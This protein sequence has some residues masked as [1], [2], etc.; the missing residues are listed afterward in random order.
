MRQGA[1]RMRHD[2]GAGGAVVRAAVRGAA[3]GLLVALLAVL[4]LGFSGT[5]MAQTGAG[6]APAERQTPTATLPQ[7]ASGDSGT[8]D[9]AAT[10]SAAHGTATG[11]AA[12]PT[13]ETAPATAGSTGPGAAGTGTASAGG[14]S[15]G[16]G[17]APDTT[18]PDTTAPD[19]AAPDS[20]APNSATD[21]ATDS[22]ATSAAP[23]AAAA[24]S[25]ATG[26]TPAGP[27]QPTPQQVEPDYKAWDMVATRGEGMVEAATASPDQLASLRADIV[28]WR[29][30]FQAAQSINSGRIATVRDQI[31]AL[32]PAPAEGQTEADDIAARRGQLTAQLTELQ[33]P[34]VRAVEAYSRA[35]ALVRSI[36]D[37]TRSRQTSAMLTQ[38][39]MPLLPSSL[40]AAWADGAKVVNGIV[41]DVRDRTYGAAGKAVVGRLPLV[42]AYLAVALWLLIFGRRW[43]D[44]LPSRL[45]SRAS[46]YTR[47]ALTFGVSLGQIAIPSA[48]A[49]LLVMALD[50]TGLAGSWARPILIALPLTALILFSGRWLSRRFFPLQSDPPICYSETLRLRGRFW[51]TALAAALA[52]HYIAST[53]FLPL[54]GVRAA[55]GGAG[56]RIPL[57]VS[58]AAAGV[59]HLPI[60]L[61]GA[62]C[63]YKL[64]CVL[65]QSH[66]FSPADT[67][68][69]RG[70]VI[71]ILG[72]IARVV[73]VVSPIAALIGYVTLG[74]AV[75]WSTT[76]SVALVALIIVLQ[77]LIADLWAIVKRDREGSRAALAPVLIGFALVV[78]SVPVFA[79][80]W[81][82]GTQDLAEG[83]SQLRQGVALGGVRLSP[84]AVLTFLVVFTAGYMLTRVVQGTV[85]NSILPR[86]RL[87]AGAQNAAVAGLG[88]VGVFL[89]ALLA[90][91]SAGIDLSSF[92][93]VAGALSVGIGFGMQ[94]IVSN[95]VSGIILLVERPVAVGDWIQVG[96]AQGYVRRISVRSTQI[97]TFDRTDVIVPNSDLISKEVT[98]WTRGNLQ[99]RI[100]VPVGVAYGSDTRKVTQILRDIAE[101]QPIVLINPAPSVL[102]VNFGADSLDFEIRAILSDVNQGQSVA[103]E[104]RHQII[105]RFAAEGIDI[106]YAHREV[107]I[108]NAHEMPGGPA[109]RAAASRR[110]GAG[111]GAG[112]AGGKADAAP[113]P[114]PAPSPAEAVDPRIAQAS[115]SGLEGA[116]GGSDGDGD[117]RG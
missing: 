28:N 78:A 92:A 97:Q 111:A 42:A 65:R 36:D 8:A 13:A 84:G 47:D 106:P 44:S 48:G 94:N 16:A 25:T 6:T 58:D 41:Q 57:Q 51:G 90:I 10:G 102:F 1:M 67:P 69:Y 63:L 70:K 2:G 72:E 11:T 34:S 32:G 85:R 86:T 50:T 12:E 29:D 39:P 108:V 77:E 91:T 37:L 80:I 103:T 81:G 15:A 101:D 117:G 79:L 52:V 53:V 99:G 17:A 4:W 46:E 71:S 73:A 54:G 30:R 23:S 18:A 45:S 40:A 33:A 88:Y 110:A 105:E 116:S 98:N 49:Y 61:A 43:I 3:G 107:R 64:A 109:A 82:A 112:D 59:W 68:G 7:A 62:L 96:N 38:T 113:R 74:N 21:S 60:I 87:D 35:D 115:S 76:M 27:P 20:A 95:F 75:L 104:I 9:R 26:R 22:A 114:G 5:A 55:T 66:K 19:G 93:I 24:A 14:S 89:A 56:T 83:W 100:I 31:S